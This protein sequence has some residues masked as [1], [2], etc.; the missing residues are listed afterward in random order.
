MDVRYTQGSRT[1]TKS[2]MC[3]YLRL[4]EDQLDAIVNWIATRVPRFVMRIGEAINDDASPMLLSTIQL[5]SDRANN[6]PYVF[7]RKSDYVDENADLSDIPKSYFSSN[8]VDVSNVTFVSHKWYPEGP[9]NLER[10]LLRD[11]N[12]SVNTEWIW[13]DHVC[14]SPEDIFA[15][16]MN[17]CRLII[18]GANFIIH[19]GN[20]HNYQHSAWCTLERILMQVSKKRPGDVGIFNPM[21]DCTVT[22]YEPA[23]WILIVSVLMGM[24]GDTPASSWTFFMEKIGTNTYSRFVYAILHQLADCGYPFLNFEDCVPTMKT[25]VLRMESLFGR[26]DAYTV[27]RYLSYGLSGTKEH[28]LNMRINENLY[29]PILG[30]LLQNLKT[31]IECQ[32]VEFLDSIG[33]PNSLAFTEWRDKFASDCQVFFVGNG[34]NSSITLCDNWTPFNLAQLCYYAKF[35]KCSF[36]LASVRYFDRE[37]LNDQLW[38]TSLPALC[39]IICGTLKSVPSLRGGEP[40]RILDPNLLFSEDWLILVVC[41]SLHCGTVPVMLESI[42]ALNFGTNYL[43][44]SY[45]GLAVLFAR[46]FE[47]VNQ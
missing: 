46:R 42:T 30:Q 3:S 38:G 18:Q 19:C 35:S 14:A 5:L 45:V 28:R 1:R 32:N 23:D 15:D 37:Q 8:E 39:Q 9:D 47:F 33:N 27:V 10:H 31:R 29:S 17:A 22:I 4:D 16:V 40:T 12:H 20:H 36:K 34:S 2:Y 41:L 13:I 7:V 44:H 21:C 43:H 26:S 11:I 24:F 25:N 6:R